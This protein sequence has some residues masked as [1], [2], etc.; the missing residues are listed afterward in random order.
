MS[1]VGTTRQAPMGPQAGPLR[2]PA[3]WEPH[4]AT[5]LAWPKNAETWPNRLDA[6]VHAYAQMV[7]ALVD[8][9]HVRILVDDEAAEETSRRALA[10]HGVYQDSKIDYH[11]ILTDDAWIRD[12]APIVVYRDSP[13]AEDRVW[14]DFGFNAWGGKYP[15]WSADAEAGDQIVRTQE[16][17]RFG[18]DEILEGGSVDGNGAGILMTTES[19]LLHPNRTSE[20]RPRDRRTVA[21]W[22]SESLGAKKLIW[23]SDGIAGDDTDGHVDDLAR[24]VGP[25]TILAVAEDDVSD[26]NHQALATNWRRLQAARNLADAAFDLI[27]LPMPPPVISDGRRLPA[28]YANFY[29]GNRVVLMPKF[30]AATDRRAAAI[31]QECFPGREIVQIPCRDLVVGLGT[32]HCLTQ[33]EPAKIPAGSVLSEQET[34]ERRGTH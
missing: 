12:Y 11:R 26:V 8:G 16:G 2:W 6:V 1:A 27:A 15:P 7:E 30:E 24:F 34:N 3:E 25:N 13:G 33:Q 32:T 14:L 19:C 22:L 17:V 21:R 4:A 5:W 23:L 10:H 28:S 29:I 20:G 31:L 18:V 9:E